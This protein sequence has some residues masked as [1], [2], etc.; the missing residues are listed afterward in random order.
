MLS[1]IFLALV[2]MF[3][4]LPFNSNQ[5]KVFDFAY[6]KRKGTEITLSAEHFKAFTKEWR[7]SDYYYYTESDGLICSVLFYKL[8][9]N[10]R[11]DL[12]DVPKAAIGGPEK[13]PAYPYSYFKNYSNLKS[14]ERNDSTWGSPTDDFMFR[15]NDVVLE[16]TQFS[17]KNMYGYAMV[18]KDLFVNI[19][20]SKTACSNSDSTEMVDILKSLTIK[21]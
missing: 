17:Q 5:K 10:E 14:M 4:I 13:S 1:K 8:N 15:Q 11:K 20:L 12:I 18:D 7:G 19:H 6:P 16:G 9:N 2:T 3:S 21:K